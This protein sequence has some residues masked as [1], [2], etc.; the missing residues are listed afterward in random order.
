MER[1]SGNTIII[2]ISIVSPV[3]LSV[4]LSIDLFFFVPMYLSS[5]SSF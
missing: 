1:R 3:H 2:I 4:C 5:C